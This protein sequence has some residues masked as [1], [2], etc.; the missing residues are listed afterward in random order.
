MKNK[1]LFNSLFLIFSITGSFLVLDKPLKAD[2]N[3]PA[4]P[5]PSVED[6]SSV[7]IFDNDPDTNSFI[8]RTKALG[9]NGYCYSTPDQY[10]VKVFKMGFCK[11]NP[12]N[13]TGSSNR[14]G[15]E[16]DYT[17]CTWSYEN[18]VGENADFEPGGFVDLSGASSIPSAGTYPYAAMIISNKIRLKG[19]YGPVGGETYYSITEF[20]NSS[21]N[22]SDYAVTLA[23]V[24][25]FAGPNYCKASIEGTSVSTGTMSAY[26]IN[27]TGTIIE[28]EIIPENEDSDRINPCPAERLLG[29]VGLP[30]DLTISD[31]TKGLKTTFGVTDA[32]NVMVEDGKL[33]IAPN[34][35]SVNFEAF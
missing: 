11:Q 9:A 1:T 2:P 32:M 13:P 22:I 19:K 23:P 17:S 35:F 12:G 8:S 20:D 18:A 10:G 4:C 6:V 28:S 33:V 24:T 29:V 7:G 25:S 16:P 14:E 3:T 27:N 34:G 5:D 30:N 15:S 26:L 31:A 21:T